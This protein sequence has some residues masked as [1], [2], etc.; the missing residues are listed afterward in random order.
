MREEPR[1]TG[2]RTREHN[3]TV[4]WL[5]LITRGNAIATEPASATPDVCL[6]GRGGDDRRRHGHRR[7]AR[8][9]MPSRH[10]PPRQGRGGGAGGGRGLP[11]FASAPG[12][13]G[14]GGP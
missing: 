10:P 4:G 14:P 13:A 11:G 5:L 1:V 12:R 2:Y 9:E 3:F 8:L 6:R 7:Q